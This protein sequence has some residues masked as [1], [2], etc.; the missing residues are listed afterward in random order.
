MLRWILSAKERRR[1][2]AADWLARLNGAPTDSERARFDRWYADVQNRETF[3]RLAGHW[4]LAAGLKPDRVGKV[5]VR[6]TAPAARFALAAA[7]MGAIALSVLLIASPWRRA[8]G[9]VEQL[10]FTTTIGEIREFGLPDG[11][12]VTLDTDSRVAVKYSDEARRVQLHR[13]RARFK[14]VKDRRPFSVEAGEALVSG[15]VRLF[16]V[17]L[18]ENGLTVTA[19]EGSLDLALGSAGTAGAAARLRAPIDP[20]Q[21]IMVPPAVAEADVEPGGSPPSDWPMGMLEFDN[22]RLASALAEA[23]RYSRNKISLAEPH[24]GDLRVTGAFRA[25]DMTALAASIAAAFRL[26]VERT[27]AGDYLIRS[28][29]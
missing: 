3:D 11:S 17:A 5:P 28:A 2:Q 13:G 12:R 26:R 24:L 16:D 18:L 22:A 19:I 9:Q 4:G 21:T 20:G 25:G 8:E 1:R 14:V 29:E 7:M 27:P 6:S 23:N 10:L 15:P